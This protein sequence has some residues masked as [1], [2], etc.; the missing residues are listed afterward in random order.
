TI[1]T[2]LRSNNLPNNGAGQD[3]SVA[4]AQG[5]VEATLWAPQNGSGATVDAGTPLA[6]LFTTDIY[7]VGRPQGAGWDIGAYEFCP[8]GHCVSTLPGLPDPQ[9]TLPS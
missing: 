7:G 1:G 6:S 8:S 9:L 4:M 2:I 5:Y 3:P